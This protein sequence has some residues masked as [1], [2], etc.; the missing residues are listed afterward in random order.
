MEDQF[1]N[2][3]PASDTVCVEACPV[4]ILPNVFT[5]NSDGNNDLFYPL[6]RAFVQRV[7]FEAYNRWGNLVYQTNDPEINW[8]GFDTNGE[9]VESGTYTYKCEIFLNDQGGPFLFNT[10]SGTIDL[11]R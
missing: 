7:N 3:G 4:Y 10:I 8:Q 6:R 5:P 2:L 11:I 1:G 9:K